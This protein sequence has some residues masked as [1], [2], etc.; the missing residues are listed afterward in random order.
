ML[1]EG[2]ALARCGPEK[3]IRAAKPE[4]K[5]NRWGQKPLFPSESVTALLMASVASEFSWKKPCGCFPV[6]LCNKQQSV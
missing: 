3:A 6:S 4:A 2:E 1:A 5:G